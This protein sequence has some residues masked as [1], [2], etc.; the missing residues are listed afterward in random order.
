[1]SSRS[2]GTYGI[3]S[4]FTLD[5]HVELPTQWQAAQ[6]RHAFAQA[7]CSQCSHGQPHCHR[8]KKRAPSDVLETR[9]LQYIHRI[10][11]SDGSARIEVDNNFFSNVRPNSPQ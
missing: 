4:T 7:E 10:W 1:M 9:G 8:D 3:E 11:D 2:A 6:N 5:K